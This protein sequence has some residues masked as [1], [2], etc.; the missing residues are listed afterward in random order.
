MPPC[1]CEQPGEESPPSGHVHLH[2]CLF[3]LVDKRHPEDRISVS[4]CLP[5]FRARARSD[6]SMEK[7]RELEITEKRKG[8]KVE[9]V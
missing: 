7:N 2:Y 5:G 9:K 6:I 8:E 3:M 4:K 1:T